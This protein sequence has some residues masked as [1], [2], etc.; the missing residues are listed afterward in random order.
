V[1]QQMLVALVPVVVERP[2]QQLVE[3][4]LALLVR[5]AVEVQQLAALALE[6]E[7]VLAVAFPA[8]LLV[9]QELLVALRL[10]VLIALERSLQEKPGSLLFLFSF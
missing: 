5:L 6:L 8:L 1:E 4:V 7:R 2:V 10:S 3:E 9:A